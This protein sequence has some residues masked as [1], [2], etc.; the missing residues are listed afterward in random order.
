[1]AITQ[2]ITLDDLLDMSITEFEDAI[3]S[4]SKTELSKVEIVLTDY[5]RQTSA[6]NM[7]E[8]K[9]ALKL[10]YIKNAK[11]VKKSLKKV[12]AKVQEESK[13]ESKQ[14]STQPPKNDKAQKPKNGSLNNIPVKNSSDTPKNSGVN[15]NYQ[16]GQGDFFGKS[17]AFKFIKEKSD[18]SQSDTSNDNQADFDFSEKIKKTRKKSSEKINIIKVSIAQL[19]PKALKQFKDISKIPNEV[20][21][22]VRQSA[23]SDVP[24]RTVHRDTNT[25]NDKQAIG[26]RTASGGGTTKRVKRQTKAER[27]KASFKRDEL[28]F[29]NAHLNE[30]TRKHHSDSRFDREKFKES[31]ESNNTKNEFQK[32]TLEFRQKVEANK[33]KRAEINADTKEKL[34]QKHI[35]FAKL[36]H[37]KLKIKTQADK[38]KL[39]G[40]LQL[41]KQRTDQTNRNQME[42]H[43]HG[44]HPALGMMYG[45][46]QSK[47]GNS[48][49]GGD[50]DSGGMLSSMLGNAVGGAIGGAVGM[51]GLGKGWGMGLG[52]AAKGVSLN[53]IKSNA[54]KF[55]AS[56][57]PIVGAAV[58]G[59][60][61]GMSTGSVGKGLAA[62]TGQLVG[63]ALGGAI[64]LALGGP[65][66]AWVGAFIGGILGTAISDTVASS[67]FEKNLKKSAPGMI[68]QTALIAS[69]F[70][71]NKTQDAI[72]SVFGNT[73]DSENKTGVDQTANKNVKRAPNPNNPQSASGKIGKSEA[74]GGDFLAKEE[75]LKLNAYLDGA[76]KSGKDLVSIGRGHQ[77]KDQ[78]YAQGFIQAGQDR[79]PISG[80][81]GL[82][83]KLTKEQAEALYKIDSEEYSN[84]ARSELGADVYDKLTEK[85]KTA[86]TSYT[87]N[88]G[89]LKSL[90]KYGLK[91]KLKSGDIEGAADII[92][93]KGIRTSKGKFNQALDDRRKKEAAMIVEKAPPKVTPLQDSS[94][95]VQEKSLEEKSKPINVV[96]VGGSSGGSSSVINNTYVNPVNTDATPRQLANNMMYPGRLV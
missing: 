32:R 15:Y 23:N 37:E 70:A 66:G 33:Q 87:Y 65:P 92:R 77:I 78:E 48:P 55:G 72:H 63:S 45:M 95:R 53:A 2:N 9:V 41:Q 93:D 61:E 44:I 7:L 5:A 56:K 25:E 14:E 1:M 47:T 57:L 82:G 8:N 17:S 88:T 27:D 12:I 28:N 4:I 54:F 18:N 81:K 21:R 24:K 67:E 34:A 52:A 85:Q 69:T 29:K 39:D 26:K 86:L 94:N 64:G 16:K 79:I 60:A 59:I 35:E 49:K 36:N 83:T 96:N 38:D 74:S 40:R 58:V 50:E 20:S 30:Q 22:V 46:S 51:R 43:M 91:D 10:N 42:R 13:Q 62:G 31:T 76:T 68:F 90:I 11:S 75:G 6:R 89:S 19:E 73:P 84:I 3:S 80:D 71:S